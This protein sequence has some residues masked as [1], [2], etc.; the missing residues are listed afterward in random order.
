[1]QISQAQKQAL[2]DNL[3]L[4]D[5]A[6]KLRADYGRQALSLRSR[7]EFRLNRIPM[8]LRKANMGELLAT[9]TETL[10]AKADGSSAVPDSVKAI[11][12]GSTNKALP[13]SRGSKPKEAPQNSPARTRGTKRTSDDIDKENAPTGTSSQTLSNP[14]KRTK[15]NPSTT[16]AAP[17]TRTTSRT[18]SRAKI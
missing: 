16:S 15:I 7:L 9:Y 3:Q 2:I 13:T 18:T 17:A 11:E 4:E 5:R 8:S 14:K 10:K 1:M 6:R 12:V